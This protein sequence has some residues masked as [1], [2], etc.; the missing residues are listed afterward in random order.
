MWIAGYSKCLLTENIPN[1]DIA[2]D[3][4]TLVLLFVVTYLYCRPRPA[5]LTLLVTRPL[6]LRNLNI[7][8]TKAAYS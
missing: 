6:V 7:E 3:S 2:S 5:L 4:G 1:K 8:T